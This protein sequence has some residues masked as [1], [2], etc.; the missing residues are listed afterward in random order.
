LDLGPVSFYIAV[1]CVKLYS[2]HC[3]QDQI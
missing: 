3:G 1:Q 2:F